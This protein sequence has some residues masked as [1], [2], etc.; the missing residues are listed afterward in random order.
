MNFIE[1]QK[2]KGVKRHTVYNHQLST[3]FPLEQ[4]M[5]HF[6]PFAHT[7]S[8]HLGSIPYLKQ[9]KSAPTASLLGWCMLF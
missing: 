1:L 4:L 3:F 7:R 5:V 9:E 6:P 2:F 8:S